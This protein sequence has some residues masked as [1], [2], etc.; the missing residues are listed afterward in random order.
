MK[1]Y[2]VDAFTDKIFSGNPA[3][4]CL[5]PPSSD[6]QWMQK[7]AAEMNLSETAFLYKE[8]KG[9][10][11]RWFTPTEEVQLCGHATLASA[12]VLYEQGIV[13]DGNEIEFYTLS[14][15]L[16]TI[17]TGEWIS[18]DFPVIETKEKEI[19]DVH[20]KI[21]SNTLMTIHENEQGY[22]I[23]QLKTESDVKNFSPDFSLLSELGDF[24]IIITAEA[25]R[26]SSFDFVTRV[27]APAF[28]VNEDPVTGSAH[29]ALVYFWS[30]QLNRNKFRACQIS[31][32]GGVLNI[33]LKGDRTI[34]SGQ[35]VTVLKGELV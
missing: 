12:H 30:Q 4:V 35:A 24:L 2:Q 10:R 32:R 25:D 1:I 23:A 19:N 28:G 15:T 11:L 17:K 13:E 16:T 29:C 14:G 18:M 5:V 9:F 33:T 34:L 20:R 7:V 3:A 8:N 26:N 6:K 22:L 31:S 21:F 27:F